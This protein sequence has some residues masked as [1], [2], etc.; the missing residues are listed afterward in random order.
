MSFKV[1][2]QADLIENLATM[3]EGELMD[4]ATLFHGLQIS[5]PFPSFVS[6]LNH[7]GKEYE[8]LL[9][10]DISGFMGR[11]AGYGDEWLIF[12]SYSLLY[13]TVTVKR[14]TRNLTT[15]L[16]IFAQ[17]DALDHKNAVLL[18]DWVDRLSP[19]QQGEIE[20]RHRLLA[21]PAIARKSLA[22]ARDEALEE[23]KTLFNSSQGNLAS[24][25]KRFDLLLELLRKHLGDDLESLT[26]N[27]AFKDGT[28]I[29]SAT[30]SGLASPR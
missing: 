3:S 25:E 29:H 8:E 30:V 20:M 17:A 4:A 22:R 27:A 21:G 6:T 19:V 14:L 23:M 2:L 10:D 18:A 16:E 15:D 24:F 13:H 5:G 12:F 7:E 9:S 28:V 11:V 1:Y 26:L